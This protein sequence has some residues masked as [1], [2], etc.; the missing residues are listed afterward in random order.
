MTITFNFWYLFAPLGAIV[1]ALVGYNRSHI[2][3]EY[4]VRNEKETAKID[5][6]VAAVFSTVLC[7][8]IYAESRYGLYQLFV[9]GAEDAFGELVGLMCCLAAPVIVAVCYGILLRKI[10]SKCA[11]IGFVCWHCSVTKRRSSDGRVATVIQAADIVQVLIASGI[12]KEALQ[13]SDAPSAYYEPVIDNVPAEDQLP[14][15]KT[16]QEILLSD[17]PSKK[18]VETEVVE[19]DGSWHKVQVPENQVLDLRL[20][21]MSYCRTMARSQALINKILAETEASSQPVDEATEAKSLDQQ[22]VKKSML[23]A[24]IAGLDVAD[25][26]IIRDLVAR[27]PGLQETIESGDYNL[28]LRL[29][30]EGAERHVRFSGIRIVHNSIA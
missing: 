19:P 11:Q 25:Q 5:Y 30:G 4:S 17:P 13:S 29:V 22:E 26:E 14:A 9:A 28:R 12:K 20:T 1:A 18:L 8:L 7:V 3:G 16:L 6:L 27:T 2:D 21:M 10:G 24:A 23:E 15:K